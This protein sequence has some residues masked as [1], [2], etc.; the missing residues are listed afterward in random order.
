MI[1]SAVCSEEGKGHPKTFTFQYLILVTSIILFVDKFNLCVW[2]SMH[3]VD[4]TLKSIRFADVNKVFANCEWI[5][6]FLR[7]CSKWQVM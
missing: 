5:S 2:P 3:F 4:C 7:S 1:Y 6:D